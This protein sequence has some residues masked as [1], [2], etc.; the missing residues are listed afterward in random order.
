MRLFACFLVT[1]FSLLTSP[2]LSAAEEDSH[3]RG[4]NH[5]YMKVDTSGALGIKPGEQIDYSDIV[6]LQLRRGDIRLRPY[7]VNQPEGNIP[8]L[9]ISITSTANSYD[10][11]LRVRDYVTIDRNNEKTVATIFEMERGSGSVVTGSAMED[12]IKSS[13]RD[14][15]TD[16]VTV[17][18][19]QNKN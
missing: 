7:V 10:L 19:Q 15:M 5:L 9:E 13:L 14:L 6:E 18:R 8:V 12:A 11:L 3:L 4:I 17:F 16:F 2:F 1:C